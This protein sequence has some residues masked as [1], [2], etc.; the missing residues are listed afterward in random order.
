MG[1]LL[2][3]WYPCWYIANNSIV[4]LFNKKMCVMCLIVLLSYISGLCTTAV[5]IHVHTEF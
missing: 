3:S 4:V 1:I 5:E 2:A